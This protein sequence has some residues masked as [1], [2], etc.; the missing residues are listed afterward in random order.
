MPTVNVGD[1][2][3]IVGGQRSG[4]KAKVLKNL[5]AFAIKAKIIGG[6]Y[7]GQVLDKVRYP[8]YKKA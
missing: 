3:N 2:V 4:N 1:I 5:N 6:K 7:D 8:D